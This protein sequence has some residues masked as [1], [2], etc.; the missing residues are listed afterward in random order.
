MDAFELAE[1]VQDSAQTQHE[2]QDEM[3]TQ[4]VGQPPGGKSVH[5]RRPP[6]TLAL[7]R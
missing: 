5:A 4:Q 6:P 2:Q 1:E 7:K 3:P